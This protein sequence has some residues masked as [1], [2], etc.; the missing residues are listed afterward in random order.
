MKKKAVLLIV[1]LLAAFIFCL[2]GVGG[3]GYAYAYGTNDTVYLGGT[4]IGVV[5]GSDKLLVIETRFVIT[6]DGARKPE[7]IEQLL[8]GDLLVSLNG[9]TVSSAQDIGK[10]INGSKEESFTLIVLREGE[11][12]AITVKPLLDIVEN[13]RKLGI[14]VKSEIAGIGTLTYV[15]MDNKRFGG[16]GHQIFDEYSRGKAIY[17]KGN[18]YSANILGVVKGEAGKAG[19]LRGTFRRSEAVSGSVDRNIFT[20]VF[21]TSENILYDKRPLISLG[22]RSMVQPGTA[23][24]YTTLDGCEPRK[25]EIEI[26]KATRQNYAEDKSMVIHVTDKILLEKTGGICQGMSGSPIVQNGRLI[27]AVTHVFIND[28]TRGY[29]IYIDW[30]LPN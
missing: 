8:P 25:Y 16:L 19:E 20:G 29:G 13:N 30:M 11:Q 14:I 5:A 18:L 10:I 24:I 22:N 4:P 3:S 28:P 27:G 6:R 26:V 1:M 2:S 23:Y 15:R 17:N 7:G 12:I 9:I 21:G